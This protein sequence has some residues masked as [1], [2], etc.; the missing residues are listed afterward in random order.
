[1][2]DIDLTSE[3]QARVRGASENGTPLAIRGGGSKAFY[4]RATQGEPLDMAGHRGV[5][6]YEP[7]ELF[8]TVRAGTPLAEVE[9]LLAERDQMLPF[10]PPHFGA[11]AT[12]GGM[13]AAGLS[14][15]GRPWAGAVRDAVLGVKL[16]N[17][18]GE[19]LSFGGQVMK[20]VAGYDLSRLMAGALGT[21][22]V[23]L[24]VSLKV[25]PR[26]AQVVSLVQEADAAEAG[27][28]LADW[29]RLPLPISASLHHGGRLYLRLSGTALGVSA[30]RK[31]LGGEETDSG[32]WVAAREQRLEFFQTERPLWRL[33]LPPAADGLDLPGETLTEWGGALCWLK[34]DAPAARVRAAAT[35]AGGH[36]TLFRGHDGTAEVF[37]PLSPV[38]LGLH[39]RL[40]QSL[41]PRGILNPGR[42]YAEL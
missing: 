25:L 37:Q 36:A 9:A 19:V 22:G 14:G 41:D 20:N 3:L 4:G 18:Q 42:M 40:K 33:S 39:Q 8:I 2:T 5:V 1:M 13:V 10:E 34:T 30:A 38:L 12:V 16:I 31:A 6:S 27:R 7:T 35:V 28:R 24:E 29:G 26:P 23:I 32:I 15:P 21:L 17:G 11:T